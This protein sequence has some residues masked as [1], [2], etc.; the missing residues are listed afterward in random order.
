[1]ITPSRLITALSWSDRQ[2]VLQFLH[3]VISTDDLN[4]ES[5]RREDDGKLILDTIR[6]LCEE[7]RNYST[8]ENLYEVVCSL[9]ILTKSSDMNA[10]YIMKNEPS[11]IPYMCDLIRDSPY[12]EREIS[13][14]A[15][16]ILKSLTE[17]SRDSSNS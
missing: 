16:F 9:F 4:R 11:I 12:D 5:L 7:I 1:M 8:I 14:N 13:R 2:Y 17:S 6:V 3:N 10:N 15:I